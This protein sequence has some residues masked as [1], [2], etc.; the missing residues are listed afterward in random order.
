MSPDFCYRIDLVPSD[1]KA[2]NKVAPLSDFALASRLS[3]F[4][5][6]SMPDAEL[7][8]AAARGE[9][10]RPE[11]LARQARRM[12]K[13]ERVRGLAPEFGGAWLD[14]RRFEELNTVDR[15]RFP[16]FDNELRQAMYEEPIRFMLD[17]IREN[18]SVLDFLYANHTFVNPAL[19]K[20]YGVP[21]VS[22]DKNTWVRVDDA[23][24]YDRGGL[25]PM[26]AFLTKNAPGLRTSPVKRGYWVV[27]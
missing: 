21:N 5:W 27:K 11:A 6:S 26:S 1:N 25:L 13:D 22:G 20:H 19:A 10:R 8:A 16:V 15:E 4:L 17:V 18:R 14:F 12:L 2:A 7:M 24:R 3:Y 23:N 9:L